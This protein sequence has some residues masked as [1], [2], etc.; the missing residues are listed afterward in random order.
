MSIIIS[1]FFIF[2]LCLSNQSSCKARHVIEAHQKGT[3]EKLDEME[4]TNK[5]PSGG[6]VGLTNNKGENYYIM[7]SDDNEEAAGATTTTTPTTTTD[8][9]KMMMSSMNWIKEKL[10]KHIIRGKISGKKIFESLCICDVGLLKATQIKEPRRR[11]IK[12]RLS[13]KEEV[14]NF[15]TTSKV[16]DHHHHVVVKDYEPPHGTPPIHNKQTN[17]QN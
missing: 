15:N 4:M 10:Q 6:S 8:Q 1:C 11:L 9:G 13:L 12:R 3:V 17:I 7:G 16:E 14:D 2:L 5:G